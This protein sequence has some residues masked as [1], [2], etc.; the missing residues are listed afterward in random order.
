MNKIL[1]IHIFLLS[2]IVVCKVIVANNVSTYN[3]AFRQ[4][5][6]LEG[7]PDDEIKALF[8]VPDGRLGIRSTYGLSFYDGCDFRSFPVQNSDHIYSLSYISA[9]PHIY[10]DCENRVW[11]KETGRLTVFD[12]KRETYITDVD[13]LLKSI[14]VQTHIRNFF[15]DHAHHFWW[16]TD[17]GRV[18]YRDIS[19]KR[20]YKQMPVSGKGLRDIA[21]FNGKAWFVY[22]NGFVVCREISSGKLLRNERLWQDVVAPRYPVVFRENG[23]ELWVLWNK[24]AAFWDKVSQKWIRQI[25]PAASLTSTID[26]EA[27]PNGYAW[28]GVEQNGLFLINGPQQRVIKSIP[29]LS[30]MGDNF[31]N[32]IQSILYNSSNGNLWLGLYTRGLA[33]FNPSIEMLPLVDFKKL[34]VEFDNN[35]RI[36]PLHDGNLLL[37]TSP[38][39][40]L[41]NPRSQSVT[42]VY[43][44]LK[45]KRTISAYED[46]K[47]RLWIGT[48]RKGFYEIKGGNVRLHNI[49]TSDGEDVVF[50]LIR[51]FIEDNRHRLFINFHGG[52][53]LYNEQTQ[54]IEPLYKR[55]P[56]LK[57]YIIINNISKDKD[58]CFWIAAR[59]GIY[60]YDPLR[61]KVSLGKDMVQ[62]DEDKQIMNSD[63]KAILSDSR[64]LVWLGTNDG[65]HLWNNQKRAF[66]PIKGLPSGV[67]QAVV[68]DAA[69]NIWASTANGLCRIA[70]S[71]ENGDYVCSMLFFEK[72]F[73]LKDS[74]FLANSA[75]ADSHGMVYLG[76]TSGLYSIPLSSVKEAVYTGHP[77]IT[78]FYL[79]DKE[80]LPG[81]LYNN[82]S[83]LTNSLIYT[84][85]IR[86]AYDENFFTLHFSGL[87]FADP[88][89][90]YYRYRLKGVDKDWVEISPKGGK[91]IASYT[92]LSP[93][94]YQFEVYSAGA[95]KKWSKTSA[96]LEITIDA[97]LWGTWWAKL[98]Y[99]VILAGSV[100]YY[101]RYREIQNKVKLEH[102]KE[103]ELDEMKYRFFTNISH[104]FR[105]LLTLII[106]PLSSV[107][108]RMDK[109]PLQS[110]LKMVSRNAGDLLQ[111]VNQLLDFR[112]LEM[113]GETLS[114][115]NG[116][117]GDFVEMVVLK[118]NPLA[119]QKNIHLSF[120]DESKGLYMFFDRDKVHKIIDN[121]MSN[122][123]KFT[124]AGGSVSVI[125]RRK[126]SDKGISV[127]ELEVTDTGCGMSQENMKHIFDRFYRVEKE[128]G[129][130]IGSGIG[131]NLVQEY[132]KLHKGNLHVTSKEGEGSSFYLELPIDLKP[133]ESS[134]SLEKPDTSQ[135]E[136]DNF[137]EKRS[138]TP[139]SA[140]NRTLLVVEDNDEFRKFLE[141]ELSEHYKV[142]IAADG[143]EGALMAEEKNPDLIISDIMMPRMNGIDL[144]KRIKSC[145]P[146][147]HIPV[148]LLTAKGSD[149]TRTEGYEAG[150]DAYISK[151]FD[152]DVLLARIQNLLRRQTER[153]REFSHNITLDPKQISITSKD[154]EFM[155]HAISCIEKNMADPDYMTD[156]LASDVAMSRMSLYRKVKAVTGQTPADFIRTV[157]LKYAARL[158]KTGELTVT[159][160]CEKT[161]FAT[162]QN[163]TKRFREMFG[164]LPS[165]YK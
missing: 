76:C 52:L 73:R 153:R 23:T 64:G 22:D 103:K 96:S 2:L 36:V 107:L 129:A 80:I 127:I 63:S 123:F 156:N 5:T 3:Y 111:L 47:G 46:S 165:Q 21:V 24:G 12:I 128:A 99:F 139:S 29:M 39:P 117:I 93:G 164:V 66:E 37:I 159:E 79:Y 104:E 157:R 65:L 25:I 160:V 121:L 137:P 92:N 90:T 7:L 130:H 97:P 44:Q 41:Y 19:D 119:E 118:F 148:I 154:E 82:K 51:G 75:F 72:N 100:V 122:A 145:L 56:K 144:C 84:K 112:K 142:L 109:G 53:G 67:I 88:E 77:L 16:L 102:Q 49:T 81:Q 13:S 95:D 140:T 9:N 136:S 78:S 114:L 132:V 40:L 158:L 89:H 125:L 60:K 113:S 58:G 50:N 161:G 54:M 133:E 31:E 69:H 6:V 1:R 134:E 45:G 71:K 126:L 61:D 26:L 147:S 131:L 30:M 141:R 43:P 57:P 146:T 70:V 105:T 116:N 35:L 86:L 59:Q 124:P 138:E 14:G 110:E 18:Y 8:A 106:T 17:D 15:I 62:T 74:E 151:P 115:L 155:K 38:Q 4:I 91:G 108:K 120:R 55:H 162:P 101:F 149:R 98:F 83:H 28:L 87:N 85:K 11:A 143:I 150:A 135:E 163:F 10:V 68:E 20:V 48:F 27:A 32:D 33:Y 34:N 94:T 42:S 152:M